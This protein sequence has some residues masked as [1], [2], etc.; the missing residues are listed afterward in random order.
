MQKCHNTSIIRNQLLTCVYLW[1]FNI[2][3]FWTIF[4]YWYFRRPL[5]L[6][7]TEFE[8]WGIYLL[9]LK[10][11]QNVQVFYLIDILL[12][13]YPFKNSKIFTFLGLK[14]KKYWGLQSSKFSKYT[15]KPQMRIW[16]TKSIW[17]FWEKRT[18]FNP[19]L[20]TTVL[21]WEEAARG[22]FITIKMGQK[23]M[24]KILWGEG[25]GINE[26][27]PCKEFNIDWHM[28]TNQKIFKH[29]KQTRY[30]KKT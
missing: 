20:G 23:R 1:S 6:E 11:Y 27:N 5:A 14:N 9:L 4:F 21:I 3:D 30:L 18:I 17:V 7:M 28:K 19:P 12:N 13:F 15:Y 22:I 16:F 8:S 29:Y 25:G 26:G 2:F 24:G 10:I